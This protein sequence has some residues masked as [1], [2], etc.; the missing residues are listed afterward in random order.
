[1]GT[2]VNKVDL[3]G[4]GAAAAPERV[5]RDLRARII[6]F[7][8]PP[9]STLSR[10][11][12]T[13]Q[14]RVSQT[15]VREALQRLE[16]EGLVRIFPQSR[17]VVSKIDVRQLSET[18]FLRV[19]VE[20]E[21]VRRLASGDG[22]DVVGRAKA[23]VDMQEILVGTEDQMPMF[24]DLDRTFHRTLFEGVGMESLHALLLV[25][26]GHL[27]RC[28]RLELPLEGKMR[29]IVDAHR[30]ILDGLSRRHPPAAV[31]AMRRH[32]SGTISRVE[33]I[34][35]EHPDYFTD[36]DFRWGGG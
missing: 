9:G 22:V 17:T 33:A 25:R 5:Y 12:L 6:D 2:A 24:S 34:R 10:G 14:Y 3:F 8:L 35:G 32:L 1:M 13:A 16:Q 27:Y 30:S 21:V 20:T 36:D 28:Q 18:H 19:S 23:I 11:E 15:P 31:D 7:D 29:S 4:G 26:L